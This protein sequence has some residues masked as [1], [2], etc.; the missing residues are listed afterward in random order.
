MFEA[1]HEPQ[2]VWSS[3][4]I[5]RR[6]SFYLANGLVWVG[7]SI[8]IDDSNV[9]KVRLILASEVAAKNFPRHWVHPNPQQLSFE[10]AMCFG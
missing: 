1:G 9:E 3:A 4:Q 7:F 2:Y 6:G 5:C 8:S 10:S